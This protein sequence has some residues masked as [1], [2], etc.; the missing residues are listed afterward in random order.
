M[1]FAAGIG[2]VAVSGLIW[3]VPKST[4]GLTPA[5]SPSEPPSL[6]VTA[7]AATRRDFP[8]FLGGLGTVQAF[9]TVTVKSRVGGQII[10]LPFAEGDELKQ[11][12]VVA[13]IDPRPYAAALRQAAGNTAKDEA[14][15]ANAELD[16][17]RSTNLAQK[18]FATKQ[19]LDTQNTLVASLKAAIESDKAAAESA[20]TQLDYTTITSPITGVAGLRMVDAG[21]VIA[22]SDPGIVVI[23]QLQPITV[24]FSLPEESI[25]TLPVGRPDKSFTVDALARDNTT[26]LAQGT[27]ALVD[28]RIDPATGMARLKAIFPNSDRAL[29]P[30]QFVNA[31]LRLETLVGATTVPAATVQTD[32][33]G[34]YVYVI[35]PDG[36]AGQ[37][38]I[39]LGRTAEG[40]AVVAEGLQTGEQVVLDGQYRLKPGS[41]VTV[42]AASQNV[43]NRIAGSLPG[44]P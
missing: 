11:G 13:H 22:P 23:T 25:R 35:S 5:I 43:D 19:A 16:L 18:G 2:C 30:G 44:L 10:D 27:L 17:E 28:N 14:Q 38:R 40:I 31:R 34:A 42:Q 8:V 37:R 20:Q 9:N 12:A 32:E 33:Q 26:V 6:P 7:V 1:L 24:V 3:G 39:R 41:K 21:N 15:L 29:K 36:T 4:A